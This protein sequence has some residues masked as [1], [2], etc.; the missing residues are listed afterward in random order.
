VFHNNEV[1]LLEGLNLV[2][3][4]GVAFICFSVWNIIKPKWLLRVYILLCYTGYGEHMETDGYWMCS[5]NLGTITHLRTF[6]EVYF[7]ERAWKA[8]GIN[9]SKNKCEKLVHLVGFIMGM[10]C[11]GLRNGVSVIIRRYIDRMKFA[12]YI[13]VSL[14]TLFHILLVLFCITVYVYIYIYIYIYIN[15]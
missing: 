14:I 9:F 1:V 6:L 3:F 15:L 5:L 7:G 13:V 12:A 2:I 11:E 10:W 8:I 4:Q